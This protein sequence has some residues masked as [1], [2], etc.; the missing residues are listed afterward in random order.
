MGFSPE[1]QIIGVISAAMRI[2][3][4]AGKAYLKSTQGQEIKKPL[5]W[6]HT[7]QTLSKSWLEKSVEFLFPIE[8]GFRPCRQEHPQSGLPVTGSSC[9]RTGS[10]WDKELE[11]VFFTPRE[12]K[13]QATA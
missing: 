11:P 6:G 4:L 1:L 7:H 3:L 2:I 5:T 8:L 10:L 13:G 12:L 9:G